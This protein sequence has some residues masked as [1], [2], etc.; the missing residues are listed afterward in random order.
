MPDKIFS[1]KDLRVFQN[2][3]EAAMKIY[4]LSKKFPSEEG[5]SKSLT[6]PDDTLK[7]IELAGRTCYKSEDKIDDNSANKFISMI[8]KS[9]HH[10]VLEHC[11]VTAKF[12]GSRTM[13]HQLVRHRIAAYSQESQRYC[14]YKNKLYVIMP[15]NLM[16]I[17][18]WRCHPI[19]YDEY[20]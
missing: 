2:A 16:S 10:S 9:G 18:H 19:R 7:K 14:V 6:V 15:K 4:E 12:V 17:L 1:Y 20:L 13:S 11:V 3:M 8:V 5:W